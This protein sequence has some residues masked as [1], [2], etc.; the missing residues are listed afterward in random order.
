MSDLF[1]QV[2][3]D[4]DPIKKLMSKIPGFKGYIERATRRCR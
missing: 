1:D 2:T 4:Q 3:S